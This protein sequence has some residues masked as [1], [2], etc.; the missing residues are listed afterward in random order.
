[1]GICFLYGNR[2]G[3]RSAEPA[4]GIAILHGGE[5]PETAEP[6]T[7]WIDTEDTWENYIFSPA[8][9]AGT[10][11]LLWIRT[12]IA[13]ETLSLQTPIAAVFLLRGAYVYKDGA[14]ASVAEGDVYTETG[15]K[16]FC[17]K[18]VSLYDSGTVNTAFT[19]GFTS[20]GTFLT[21]KDFIEPDY[22]PD[23]VYFESTSKNTHLMCTVNKLVLDEYSKLVVDWEVLQ[24]TPGSPTT[25]ICVTVA[26]STRGKSVAQVDFGAHGDRRTDVLDI[27]ALKGEFYIGVRSRIFT[28]ASTPMKGRLYSLELQV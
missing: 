22:Q 2:T 12:G 27:S 1:M 25:S 3:G 13:G 17:T 20:E 19:G 10:A 26:D 18:T 23:N 14:W 16:T 15:W 5:K 7:L 8:A 6:G 28:S 11:G 9:P 24:N 4:A 21:F